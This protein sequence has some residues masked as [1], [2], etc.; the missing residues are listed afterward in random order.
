MASFDYRTIVDYRLWNL[1]DVPLPTEGCGN[2]PT[3]NRPAN[4]REYTD[5]EYLNKQY[6]HNIC[7]PKRG[8]PFINAIVLS[9]RCNQSS[10]FSLI[11]EYLVDLCSV[12]ANGSPCG[13]TLSNDMAIDDL[14]SDCA[15]SNVSCTLNCSDSINDAKG[16]YV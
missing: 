15:T 8:Q 10:Y 16:S 9:S 1:C 12:D 14:N 4:V 3:V 6:I 11:T 2:G 5:E 7:L 13:L